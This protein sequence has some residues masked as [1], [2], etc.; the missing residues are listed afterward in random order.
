MTGHLYE[1][2]KA[3]GNADIHLGDIGESKGGAESSLKHQYKNIEGKELR[4]T[5]GNAL[6]DDFVE[7]FYRE[8]K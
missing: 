1:G 5:L 7:K 6:G 8:K 3:L 4:A 2:I